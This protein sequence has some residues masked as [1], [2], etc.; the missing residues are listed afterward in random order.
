MT[1]TLEKDVM[2][3]A[4]GDHEER[5]TYVL[6]HEDCMKYSQ[7]YADFMEEYPKV[8]EHVQ[9]LFMESR[10]I[11]RHAG[12]VLICPDLEKYMPV[13]KVR[14]EL[15]TPWSEGMNFRHLETHGFLKFDFLGLTTLKMVEDCT[16]LILRKQGN[17]A[18]TFADIQKF[19]DENM[20]CRYNDLDDHPLPCA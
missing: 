6:T 2:H 4:M 16:R 7:K 3:K 20:N 19:F 12:G 1:N 15:Q 13:I 11:G 14:G 17:P 5:S 9:N 10:S 8:S 18:P